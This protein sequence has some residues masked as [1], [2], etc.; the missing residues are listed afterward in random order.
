MPV[1]LAFTM[2]MRFILG[3]VHTTIKLGSLSSYGFSGIGIMGRVCDGTTQGYML[4][5]FLLSPAR[6]HSD[7]STLAMSCM[8]AISYP[9]SLMVKSTMTKLVSPIVQTIRK[10]GPDTMSIGGYL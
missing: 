5:L 7:L 6:V 3:M 1:C 9:P 4:F 10:I 8:L 2:P